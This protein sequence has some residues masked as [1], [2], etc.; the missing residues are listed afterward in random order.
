MLVKIYWSYKA[1]LQTM[2]QMKWYLTSISLDLS[3]STRLSKSLLKLWLSHFLTI[4][5]NSR[6]NNP[7]AIEVCVLLNQEMIDDPKLKQHA[8]VLF[9][10]TTLPYQSNFVSPYSCTPPLMIYLKTYSIVSHKYL[11]TGFTA[12]QCTL[13][14]F[15][16]NYYNIHTKALSSLLFDRIHQ[17]TNQRPI[18]NM[19]L[20]I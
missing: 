2:S 12:T 16:I 7:S 19:N 11:S 20:K 6:S 17:R 5:S 10:S 4:E 1:P 14:G 3:W 15:T 8:K 13:L 18:Q 9:L